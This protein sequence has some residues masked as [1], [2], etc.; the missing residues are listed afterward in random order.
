QC[1]TCE[2]RGPNQVP[3]FRPQGDTIL[4]HSWG[5]HQFRLGGPGYG[6]IGSDLFVMDPDGSHVVNLTHGQEGED[7][8]HAYWSPD[9]RQLVWTHIAGDIQ[10]MNVGDF[11]IRVADFVRDGSGPHLVNVRV[12]HGPVPHFIETQWWAPDGAGF[13][14]TE[15]VG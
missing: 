8:Y 9:G 1:L 14:Y 2:L 15:S 13:L 3:H 7:N 5:D 6:G 4:F 11:D 10:N 12:V